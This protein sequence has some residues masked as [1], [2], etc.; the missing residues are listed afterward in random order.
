MLDGVRIVN[1][2]DLN[3]NRDVE[4]LR[5]EW[6]D[7]LDTLLRAVDVWVQELGWSTRRIEKAMEDSEIGPYRAPA[8]LMQQDAVRILLDPI[9]R[10]AQGA[11]GVVD[12][13][14]LPA[15]DDIASI[16]YANGRW[17]LEHQLANQPAMDTTPDVA[18]KPLSKEVLAAAIEAMK[19]SAI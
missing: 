11:E 4:R 3:D 14:L 19:A 18:S 9:A 2:H 13:Y 10:I 6:L 17:Q 12:L 16:F 8:L 5:T 15:Y 7:K 1:T